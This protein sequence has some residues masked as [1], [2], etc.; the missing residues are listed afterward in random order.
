M[1]TNLT[2]MILIC[3]YMYK[4]AL[5]Q[6]LVYY[7]H[8]RYVTFSIIATIVCSIVII[9]TIWHRREIQLHQ[10]E[11]S[12]L[13][14]GLIIIMLLG[15]IALPAQSLSAT[16]ALKRF[17]ISGQSVTTKPVG[18]TADPAA[19]SSSPFIVLPRSDD[20]GDIFSNFVLNVDAAPSLDPFQ[21]VEVELVGFVLIDSVDPVS[22]YHVSRFFI[23]CC[24]ADANPI[25]IPFE[26]SGSEYQNDD[27]VKVKGKLKVVSQPD[28]QKILIVPSSIER[29]EKPEFPYAYY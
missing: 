7:I 5:G 20:P 21:G 27:W 6:D 19:S 2:I 4:L 13:L 8:P 14:S 15:A 12:G 1:K 26:Y 22:A 16:T 29:V 18:A 3:A 9:R 23:A 25:G 10:D 24:A 28:S 17:N 11:R